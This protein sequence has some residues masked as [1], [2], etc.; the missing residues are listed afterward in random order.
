MG[1]AWKET[2]VCSEGGGIAEVLPDEVGCVRTFGADGK[3]EELVEGTITRDV[4]GRYELNGAV[5]V[6]RTP[7]VL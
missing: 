2:A 4:A 1:R 3:G 6:V 7:V 5:H